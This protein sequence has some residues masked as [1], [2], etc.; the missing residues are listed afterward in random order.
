MVNNEYA[1]EYLENKK[2]YKTFKIIEIFNSSTPAN[3]AE[4]T[5]NDLGWG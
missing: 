1:L 5:K 3:T 4:E 2:G